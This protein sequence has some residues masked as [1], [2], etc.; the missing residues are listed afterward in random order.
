MPKTQQSAVPRTVV[1]ADSYDVVVVGAGFS[2]LYLLHS[3]RALGKRVVLLEAADGVGGVWY[4]NRYPGAR[5]DV[6][7]MFYSYSFSEELEQEWVWSERYPSQ[8]EILSYLEHVADRFDLRR[9][10]RL[11]ARVA[12]AHYEESANRWRVRTDSGDEL[13]AT[14]CVMA[15]GCLSSS[16]LPE[17][18]GLEDFEGHTYHTAQ[19]PHEEVDFTGQHV[20]VIGTGSSGIQS[21]PRIAEQAERLTVFQR[22]PAF[23]MPAHNRPLK[24]GEQEEIKRRFRQLRQEARTSPFGTHGPQDDPGSAHDATPEEREARYRAAWELGTLNGVLSTYNDLMTDAGANETAARFVRDR[25]AELVHDPETAALLTPQD[26]P[27]GAKRPCLDTGYYDTFNQEHVELVDVRAT[28]LT[29]VTPKG[30]AT[31]DRE[32]AVDSI[33]F[34]TGFDAMTGALLSMDIRGRDGLTLREKWADGPRTYLGLATAGFPNLF[35]VAG[36]GSPSVLSNMV[37]SIEQ[38][39]EWITDFVAHL[40]TRDGAVFEAG[41]EAE[42]EWVAHVNEVAEATLYPRAQ[43]WYLGANVPGKPRV[44]MPYPGGCDVYRDKCDAV[45]ANG[46]EGFRVTTA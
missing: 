5:C 13:T 8:A 34:A 1:E 18:D 26:Y 20:A 38:H 44:F 33:V 25:I 14:Y 36:P 45:A 16:K 23:T 37:V 29:R 35:L 11:S 42:D 22:T 24:D 4:W 41:R 27:F 17:I 28:P 12:A 46:Y 43:S 31:T 3:L 21:I 40:D 39:V 2:G 6:E 7:S 10:I 9:D 32:T 30:V 19:W 15:T